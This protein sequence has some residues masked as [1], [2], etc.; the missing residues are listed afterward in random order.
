M[1][2]VAYDY[3]SGSD[4]AITDEEDESLNSKV[5][6]TNKVQAASEVSKDYFYHCIKYDFILK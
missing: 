6:I 2:L 1:A 4:D 3:S 5:I